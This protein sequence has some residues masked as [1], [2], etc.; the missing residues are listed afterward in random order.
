M[1]NNK[2]YSN[3]INI[4][5]ALAI[6]IVVSGH[7]EFSL[8][9]LFP[10]YSFQVVLFFFIAGML[11]KDSYSF[12]QYFFRRIKSLLIPYFL[13]S[14]IYLLITIAITPIIGK[15]WAM[16]ITFKNEFIYPFLTGHQI[17]LTSPLWFVPQLFTTLI[18]FKLLFLY[19]K[20]LPVIINILF[21][22]ILSIFAI[23]LGKYSQNVY[24]LYFL[25]TLF[26]LLFVYL[27]YLYNAKIEGKINIFS[28]KIFYIII[29]I[30]SILW[31][32]NADYSALDGIGL[33]YILVWG[34]FDN[35]IVPII[36]SITGIW[37][38]LFIVE[39]I[40]NKVKTWSFIQKIGQNT[41]H[42]MANHLLVF[43]IITYSILAFKGIPFDIKNNSDIYWFY[44]PLKTTY[45]YFVVGIIVTTYLGEFIKFLKYRLKNL[46]YKLNTILN[47]GNFLKML[48][49]F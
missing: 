15:F 48:K 27:G 29:F 40:Y 23:Q 34:D 44:C 42:I 16:P 31:L 3:K 18:I 20:K 9:P 14:F 46:Y 24:I 17:D 25:R 10:P 35:W 22:F 49:R 43:N 7:L 45:F 1:E 12:F 41:Y 19:L 47:K 6:L 26:S 39:I 11:F 38:S 37:M 8:I 28:S 33:S 4:L 30:Q 13:Y 21:F 36:T 2:I 5:K 32:T